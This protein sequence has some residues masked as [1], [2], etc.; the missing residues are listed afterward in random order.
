M[1]AH[2]QPERHA[3]L[4]I[5]ARKATKQGDAVIDALPFAVDEVKRRGEARG[6]HTPRVFGI[7]AA[8][9]TVPVD[10]SRTH[11][12]AITALRERMNSHARALHGLREDIRVVLA[13]VDHSV[14]CRWQLRLSP[15]TI[16]WLSRIDASIMFDAK[17]AAPAGTENGVSCAF[18]GISRPLADDDFIHLLRWTS[19]HLGMADA[20]FTAHSLDARATEAIAKNNR[21]FLFQPREGLTV[22]AEVLQQIDEYRGGAIAVSNLLR[23]LRATWPVRRALIAGNPSSIDI[24]VEHWSS[25]GRAHAFLTRRDVRRMA[26]FRPTLSYQLVPDL[27]PQFSERGECLHCDY[28]QPWNPPMY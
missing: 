6:P 21:W 22:I 14:V 1:D 19:P 20:S 10:A 26:G 8:F 7:S 15:E 17:C 24:H 11:D 2:N 16:D 23:E 9:L 3:V 25:S 4:C 5:L 18:C 12:D 13:V 27:K 28:V